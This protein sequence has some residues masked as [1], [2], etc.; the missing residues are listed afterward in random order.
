MRGHLALAVAVA[1]ALL[2]PLVAIAATR[3]DGDRVPAALNFERDVAPI[4]REKCTGCHQMGG[5][6]PFP[7]E[8]AQQAQKWSQAISAAVGAKIMPPWP[9][10]PASP[11]YVGQQTHQLTAKQLATI[12][13]WAE[14]GGRA[15][16]RGAG[17]RAAARRD[18]RRGERV[19][20][21]TMPTAYTPQARAGKTDEYRC[22]LLDPKLSKGS[23]VTSVD[24]EP[25]ARSIVHHVNLNQLPAADRSKAMRRDRA[26]P[27]PGWSCF[28]GQIPDI[29]LWNTGG[30]ATRLP[31]GTGIFLPKGSL[32]VMQVHYNLL[33]GSTTDRSRAIF[34]LAPASSRLKAI[35]PDL[36]LA[37]VELA[38]TKGETGPLCDRTTALAALG[39]KY[40]DRARNLPGKLLALCGRATGKPK[41]STT[42]TCTSVPLK[43]AETIYLVAGHMHLLGKAIRIELNPGT[44]AHRVLLDIPRWDFHWQGTYRLQ[45]PVVAKK[46]D[47]LRLTCKYDPARRHHGGRGI[48]KTPRYVLWGDGSADEM[49]LALLQV[50]H[51]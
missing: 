47:V 20:S 46:G 6:A 31:N 27:G 51:H 19:L 4:L 35:K 38:C 16:G 36:L 22:F 29:A 7:L 30:E 10:G 14:A 15:S 21:V 32:V 24:V 8:T 28:G 37:P 5:I 13:A 33:H 11:D 12:R 41:P 2:V 3:G 23:F 39:K 49:C 18:V 44:A 9:P 50:V 26:S 1:S 34:T 40:G 48:P 45:K 43:R 25:G 17:R 42:S